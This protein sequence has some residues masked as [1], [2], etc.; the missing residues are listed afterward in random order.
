MHEF[1]RYDAPGQLM[2][3]TAQEDVEIGERVIPKGE[4]V[5]LGMG[6]A[7]RDPEWFEE[8]DS[9]TCDARRARAAASTT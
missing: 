3:R 6:A 7:N 8:P 1:Y 5:M 2:A 4:T 9:S